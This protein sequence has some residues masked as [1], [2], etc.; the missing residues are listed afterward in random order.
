VIQQRGKFQKFADPGCHW[1]IPCVC[2]EVA[3]ALSTRVQALDVAV[4]T[5]TKD[6]VFVT[7]I[8][9][10]QYMVLRESSRMYDAFYKLTDSR[11]Q[12]RSYIFDVVRSTVP[13]INL[14]DV[15]TTKEEIAIEVKNMLEKAMT[16]FGYTIIQ[17]LVTDIAPDHK[18]KTASP[19]R[20]APRL[21]RSWWSRRRRRTRRPST[22][23]V[24]V[25]RA[26]GRRSST[27][28]GRAW[29]TSSRTSRT[30]PPRT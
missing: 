28:S 15:F 23:R 6:N 8:V 19:R 14:D 9:S 10:T 16:E 22:W 21:R 4:E 26:R 30:S 7:I 27:A 11:E 17:T 25:S 2:Q 1:V 29:C 20:T 12:I 5:K 24:R 13:R 3:G 18:V